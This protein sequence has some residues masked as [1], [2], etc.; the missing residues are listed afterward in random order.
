MSKKRLYSKKSAA[1]T[2]ILAVVILLVLA[3]F[4][5]GSFNALLAEDNNNSPHVNYFPIVAQPDQPDTRSKDALFL[6]NQARAQAGVPPVKESNDLNNNCFEHARYMAENNVLAHSQNPNL[7][8]ASASGQAC[9]QHGNTWLGSKKADPGWS[10][11]D[12]VQGWMGSVGHRLWIL[13]PTT[14]TVG[15]GFF[16]TQGENRAGAALDILSFA[17]FGNDESFNGWPIKYPEGGVVVPPARYPITL[18]WRYFGATPELGQTQLQ[19]AAG[20]KIPHEA[21]T[22][23]PVEHKGIKLLPRKNLPP[24]SK[25]IVTINGIYEGQPFSYTWDFHTGS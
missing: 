10:P 2:A 19:T 4:F 16:S 12:S 11:Y 25:I 20:K 7:P 23:L 24:N 22:D 8:Y 5:A 14:K 13:Y 9:A 17:Q 1:R 21:S 3:I 6:V 18:N 15:F